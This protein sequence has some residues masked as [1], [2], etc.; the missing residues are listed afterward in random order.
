MTAPP[1]ASCAVSRAWEL[2]D[3]QI[4][5]LAALTMDC[6]EGGA[7]IGLPCPFLLAVDRAPRRL[8]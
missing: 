6:V 4:E 3:A 8:G 2:D 5:Q 7:S 1:I